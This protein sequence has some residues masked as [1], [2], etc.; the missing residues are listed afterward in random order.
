[1]TPYLLISFALGAMMTAAVLAVR[2]TQRNLKQSERLLQETLEAI[3][4]GRQ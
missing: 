4:K 3:R 1:M 2:Q